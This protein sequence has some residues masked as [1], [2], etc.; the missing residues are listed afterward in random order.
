MTSFFEGVKILGSRFQKFSQSLFQK[1]NCKILQ[2]WKNSQFHILK[3]PE[4]DIK[5]LLPYVSP[6]LLMKFFIL[7]QTL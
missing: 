5:Q 2:K 7:S 3:F 6:F 4:N 1:K